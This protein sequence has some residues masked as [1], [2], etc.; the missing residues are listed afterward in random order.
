MTVAGAVVTYYFTRDK[1]RLP[2]TPILSSVLRL[3]R[4][5]LGTVA[6]G[7]FI[8]TLVKIPRLILMY[9]HNQLKGRENVCARCLLKSCICCLW[10]LEKCLNY[11]NQNAYAATAINSTSFCTS[12]RD[13][14][15]IL[16][17]NALRVATINAV[18]DFVLFLGKVRRLVRTGQKRILRAVVPR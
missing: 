13:A 12:A 7:S 4:Y 2:V 8:I 16:V 18:G 17:E 9:V 10:C 1:N 11:L 6:K 3:V 15:V 14:F 5:H